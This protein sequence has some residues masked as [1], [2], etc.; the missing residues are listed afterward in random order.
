MNLT[1]TDPAPDQAA[2]ADELRRD[3]SDVAHEIRV[4]RQAIHIRAHRLYQARDLDRLTHLRNQLDEAVRDA[5]DAH[6]R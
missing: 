5:E 4:L 2:P 3:C 1:T 6:E